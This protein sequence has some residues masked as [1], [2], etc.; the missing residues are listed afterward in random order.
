MKVRRLLG[1]FLI[2]L[3]LVGCTP[4]IYGVPQP[5]WEMMSEAER[6]EAMQLYKD[7]QIAY[8]KAREERARIRA[9]ELKKQQARQEEEARKRQMR[10]DAIY[11]G[12]G[13]WGDLLRVTLRDGE[14]RI[15]GKHRG[16]EPVAFKIA[17]GETKQ[18]SVSSIA[19]RQ[20]TLRVTYDGGT[21][22]VDD[23]GKGN[24]PHAKR[25]IYEHSWEKGKTYSEVT[26]EGPL[27]LHG[28]TASIE[29]VGKQGQFRRTHEEA[30]TKPQVI[31][32]QQQMPPQPQVIV[33]PTRPTPQPPQVVII[34]EEQQK[35]APQV[36]VIKEQERPAAGDKQ[37]MAVQRRHN[38]SSQNAQK[39]PGSV[40]RVEPAQKSPKITKAVPKHKSPPAP[41]SPKEV[42]VPSRIK[43]TITKG[44]VRLK[45]K[46]QPLQP[47]T[48]YLNAGQTREIELK[49]KKR[50]SPLTVC[51]RDATLY[52]DGNPASTL[53][54]N[55]AAQLKFDQSW[56]RGKAYRVDSHG[57]STLKG[58]FV[59]I[60]AAE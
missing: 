7:R 38:P 60:A 47:V 27:K 46:Y 30:Q 49:T 3:I 53:G 5:T 19:G 56:Q 42:T 50:S 2:L 28:I 44:Q 32:I 15:G 39:K 31:I 20:A 6:L 45:G 34:K 37:G 40:P 24:H 21:L 29:I 18:V 48:F 8:Q 51:Y 33:R 22:L 35:P 58:A 57:K 41:S 13:A 26:S 52:I 9:I 54:K 36:V 23:Y 55:A 11:R 4:R 10:I 1:L 43:V 59:T 14:M 16:Y 12:N 25:F 17:A